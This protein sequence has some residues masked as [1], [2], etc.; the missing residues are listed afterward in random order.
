MAPDEGPQD[1]DHSPEERTEPEG[2][3]TPEETGQADRRDASMTN[4]SPREELKESFD[5]N[6]LI[7]RN[8]D[9]ALDV[10]LRTNPAEN[11]L[12]NIDDEEL[13]EQSRDQVQ[14]MMNEW[15]DMYRD[16]LE[17]GR[18]LPRDLIGRSAELAED[19]REEEPRVSPESRG[20][21]R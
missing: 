16:L 8:I 11:I 2:E 7:Q 1:E 5:R 10:V 15:L 17:E 20:G 6:Q 13:Q 21:R 14:S 19:M 3:T 9:M 18:P 12:K 4:P